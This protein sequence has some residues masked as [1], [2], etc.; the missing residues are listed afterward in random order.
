LIL[1]HLVSGIRIA[2]ALSLAAILYPCEVDM[3]GQTIHVLHHKCASTWILKYIEHYCR[4]NSLNM[5]RSNL[6]NVIPETAYDVVSLINASYPYLR[7]RIP[8]GI[9]I[10][11]NPLDIVVSAFFSHRNTHSL[12]GWPALSAQRGVLR[13]ASDHDGMHLTISFLER[14]D[15]YANAV[16]PLHALR[17]W[18][19]SDERFL[20][21]RMEDLVM[22][23]DG[24]IGSALQEP[25]LKRHL[26]D[27]SAFTFEAITGRRVG[28]V[29]T[30]SHYRSGAT[31]QWRNLL[32]P[33]A[34]AYISAH[35]EPLLQ[36]FY[37]EAL[38]SG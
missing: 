11:R 3:C 2:A 7:H 24:V 16:G 27:P 30:T 17:H 1:S 28:E 21:L 25:D 29:D 5:F 9:H 13:S 8:R 4:I 20:T 31:G 23:P 33:T 12:H 19:F 26:P 36:R 38:S 14:D 6:S 34:R 18:D 35:F 22:D 15:F 32:P 10:I 37:P